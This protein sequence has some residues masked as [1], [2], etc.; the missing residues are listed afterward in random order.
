MQPGD[1]IFREREPF[2]GTPLGEADLPRA[3]DCLAQV[4]D[5]EVPVVSVVDLG[6]IRAVE[7]G[8]DRLHVKVSPT[9]SGCPATEVIERD[10]QEALEDIGF[11]DPCIERVLAPAWTTDWLTE[12]GRQQLKDYG[13]APPTLR[14][15]RE[16]LRDP[17]P[18]QC[19]HCDSAATHHLPQFAAP[20]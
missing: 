11:Q 6:M 5:P 12:K 20:A 3:W 8:D 19:P 2:R 9:Y 10:V 7:W 4:P 14:Q 18:A 13:I 16:T 17:R 1:F 15:G